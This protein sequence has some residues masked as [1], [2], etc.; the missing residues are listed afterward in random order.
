VEG[1]LSDP[2]KFGSSFLADRARLENIFCRTVREGP[3]SG[4]RSSETFTQKLSSDW[5]RNARNLN[6]RDLVLARVEIPV[7]LKLA[8]DG[9]C[10]LDVHGWAKNEVDDHVRIRTNL[11]ITKLACISFRIGASE[12]CAA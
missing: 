4:C 5:S 3:I 1:N 7:F 2:V 10:L 6:A 12:R 9:N 8:L 11:V